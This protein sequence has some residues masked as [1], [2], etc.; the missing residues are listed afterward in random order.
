[1]HQLTTGV[2]YACSTAGSDAHLFL[3]VEWLVRVG[4]NRGG[5][6]EHPDVAM[7]AKACLQVRAEGLWLQT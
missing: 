1:M 4:E 5:N 6:K 7:A 2:Y 3:T